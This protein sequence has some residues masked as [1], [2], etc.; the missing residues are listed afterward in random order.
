MKYYLLHF[1]KVFTFLF[2]YINTLH[3][4]EFEELFGLK[5]LSNV[6]EHFNIRL[7]MNT[8]YKN[9]ETIDNYFDADV[10]DLIKKKS[11]QIDFYTI[12]FDNNNLIH[13]VYGEKELDT[14]ENCRERVVPSIIDIFNRKY[15][16]DFEYYEGS[17]TE[18]NIYSFY[19]YDTKGNPL[20]I[21]CNE[22]I[23]GYIYIQIVYQTMILLDEVDRFYD[24]G[25]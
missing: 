12:T 15:L 19:S 6:E 23:D 1:I 2:F 13:S 10:T 25:F 8:K 24:S 17:Y 18:F 4:E 22:G 7:L 5:L 9:P 14:I 21:Q 3:A 20:R 11:P 16:M